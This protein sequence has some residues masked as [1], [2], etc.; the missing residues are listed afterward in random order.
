VIGEVCSRAGGVI[1]VDREAAGNAVDGGATAFASRLAVVKRIG[2]G[3]TRLG[4]DS[5]FSRLGIWSWVHL[6]GAG[7]DGR[8]LEQLQA[9]GSFARG[10]SAAA[11]YVSHW[12][13]CVR[14]AG[15]SWKSWLDYMIPKC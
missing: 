11:L 3:R 13:A 9:L 10:E 6:A 2:A 7:D 15:S 12:L 14:V 1:R 4:G 8:Q 5:T